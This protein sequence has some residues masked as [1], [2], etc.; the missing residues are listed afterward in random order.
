M[1][2][3]PPTNTVTAVV[4]TCFLG[5]VR[6]MAPP[7]KI[8]TLLTESDNPPA[9]NSLIN[10]YWRIVSVLSL[11]AKVRPA[12]QLARLKLELVIFIKEVARSI[13]YVRQ[14]IRKVYSTWQDAQGRV[15]ARGLSPVA[16][17]PE[18]YTVRAAGTLLARTAARLD[19]LPVDRLG[20]RQLL[21]VTHERVDV[22]LPAG[23]V[24]NLHTEVEKS[25][26]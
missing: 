14:A 20:T 2:E 16:P 24:L 6:G 23:C 18:C 5:A 7:F 21:A 1:L 22:A 13:V 25:R 4:K 19:V 8:H 9:K 10:W 15:A 17:C 26:Y 3:F 12:N 11:R